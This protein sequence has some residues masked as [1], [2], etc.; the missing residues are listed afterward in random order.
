MPTEHFMQYKHPCLA[1]LQPLL[2]AHRWATDSEVVHFINDKDI[3]ASD[4]WCR[5]PKRTFGES[6]K[7]KLSC[8]QG[9][10]L[11]KKQHVL[12]HKI[13]SKHSVISW[14]HIHS[15]CTRWGVPCFNYLLQYWFGQMAQKRTNWDVAYLDKHLQ[16]WNRS[17]DVFGSNCRQ[18]QSLGHL[19]KISIFL[20]GT[21]EARV[22][23]FQGWVFDW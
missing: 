8:R 4:I 12:L 23:F 20:V 1:L 2:S 10:F 13:Y 14:S 15:P 17:L 5:W 7:K 21:G 22:W 18:R 16:Y 3:L 6:L 11:W 19:D 9:L